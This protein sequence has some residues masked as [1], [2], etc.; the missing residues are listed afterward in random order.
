MQRD[1]E[2]SLKE[3]LKQLLI[4]SAHIEFEH[5]HHYPNQ[6]P[7]SEIK[8]QRYQT[9]TNGIVTDLNWGSYIQAITRKKPVPAFDALDLSIPENEEFG[10]ETI[11]TRHF[12]D[13]SMEHSQGN[14]E[15]APKS[16]IQ[17][18][19]PLTYLGNPDCAKHFRIRHGAYDRDTAVVIPAILVLLLKQYGHDADF[20][21]P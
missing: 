20:A 18:I 21:I 9:I 19:N 16:L 2:G 17:M 6:L 10:T 5:P 11:F 4:Q 3:Y 12:T 1:G 13:Y 7:E 14:A 8:E 15:M